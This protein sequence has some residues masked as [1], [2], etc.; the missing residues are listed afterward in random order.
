MSTCSTLKRNPYI[1]ALLSATL[2]AV[3][4]WLCVPKEYTAITKISDEYKEV[5]LVIGL[6]PYSAAIKNAFASPNLGMNNINTYCQTLK[7]TDFARYISHVQVPDKG[8]TYGEYLGEKDTIE[9]IIDRIGYN[10]NGVKA[11]L[12][13]GFSDRDA[14]VAYQMLDSVT[15]HLQDVVTTYRRTMDSVNMFHQQKE[16]IDAEN[17]YHESQ[18]LFSLF[19]DSNQK[20]GTAT[21][22]QEK[23]YLEKE[24][25]LAYREYTEK[26]YQFYRHKYLQNRSYSSFAVVQANVVPNEPNTYLLSYIIPFVL[27]ALALTKA[28]HLYRARCRE[29]FHL[30][31]GGVFSPWSIT[32]LVWGGMMGLFYLSGDILDPLTNQFYVAIF[33]WISIM[34][35]TSF[36]TFNLLEHK[37]VPL[38]KNGI[39]INKTVFYVLFAVALV[40]SPMYMYRVWQT[41][42]AFDSDDLMKNA[43]I[44]AV[45]GE[46][47]GLLNYAIVIAQSLMLVALWRYPKIPL[48]QLLAIIFCCL[49]NSIAIME[50]GSTFLV[51][52]CSLYVLFERRVIKMRSILVVGVVVVVFFYFVNLMREGED[53]YYSQNESL[54][55]FIG[56]YV[57]SPPVAFCRVVREVEQQFGANTFET[58]YLF[59]NRF[60]AHFTV[61][62]KTQEFV[63]VPISTNVY[64]IMQPFFRDFG[65][66][67]VAFFAWIYGVLSG[68]LY[69]YS[70]NGS[71][72]CICLYTYMVEVLV[73]QFYQENLFL[74]M[75]FVLQLVFF[76]FLMTQEKIKLSYARS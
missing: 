14:L 72:L 62:E 2:I 6:N 12:L 23:K 55:D 65:Y 20:L 33:L 44:L 4:V 60:G 36:V 74:S 41:V 26:A 47:Q 68:V 42:S 17:L 9:A 16:L 75:V 71:A 67:G 39:E 70:C 64:T 63:F 43:R 5:D 52:L 21:A 34:V 59:L 69:R 15:A 24:A 54:L 22:K 13:I 57:M 11:T 35:V 73:L 58:V 76:V 29:N 53:S 40:L 30:E 28:Y 50:K 31:W 49:L 61:H 19:A 45:Y 27:I 37:S 48:W 18:E 8:M 38:P 3:V 46:G 25:V 32:I 51:I 56:M 10:L 1:I 66:L 7:T